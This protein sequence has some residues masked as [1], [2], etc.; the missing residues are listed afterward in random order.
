MATIKEIAL[1]C[2]V[3]AATVS[4]ALNNASDVGVDTA[5]RVRDAARS[6]GFFPNAAARA[7]KTNRSHN[8]GLLFADATNSGLAHEFFSLVLNS[9]K[10]ESEKQGYDVTFISR[11]IGHTGM[12][13]LEHCR[14]RH[15][16]GV[17][18]AAVTDY[19]DPQVTAL[20]QSDIP[21]VAID[22]VF[23]NRSSVLS[24]N[25]QGMRELVRYVYSMGHRKIAFIHGDRTAVTKMR[26]ASFYRTCEEL[27]LEIPDEYVI[28]GAFHDPSA[29]AKATRALLSLHD[30]PTSHTLPGRLLFLRRH[31][32]D[33]ERRALHPGRHQRLR[34]RRHPPLA[35]AAPAAHHRAPE[36]GHARC[37]SGADACGGHRK[38]KNLPA[39][40]RGGSL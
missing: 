28:A 25:V 17:V 39:P 21:L 13:Y 2:G 16:D 12:S 3:S 4:K 38:R 11:D 5:R 30:R 32:R 19:A 27:G 24:D 40:P 29:S 8:I 20:A 1:A 23:D 34:L 10:E 31:E 33:R 7:L 9:L 37:G 14:Y 6:M 15:C 36:D 22:H 18:I 26:L 35:G